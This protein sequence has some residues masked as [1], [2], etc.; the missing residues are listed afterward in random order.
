MIPSDTV[1]KPVGAEGY[2]AGL[3]GMFAF[4]ALLAATILGLHNPLRHRHPVRAAL[5]L[6]W[7]SVL[8]SY[9]LMDRRILTGEQIASADRML[10]Q[11]VA[12]TGVA[13]VAA[14]C[15]TSLPTCAGSCEH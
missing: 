9:V 14:E 8:V 1:F 2:A 10:M 15:L 12:I 11:L 6:L 5:C 13:L 3:I 4:G 7:L